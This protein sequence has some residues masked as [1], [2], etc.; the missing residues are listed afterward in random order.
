MSHQIP[1]QLKM[2]FG[3][4]GGSLIGSLVWP[5]VAA[6][7]F[8]ALDTTHRG[9]PF[10]LNDFSLLN[11][12]GFILGAGTGLAFT[13]ARGRFRQETGWLLSFALITLLFWRVQTAYN[14]WRIEGAR[15]ALVVYGIPM[16]W[17]CLLIVKSCK[18]QNTA[19]QK[20]KTPA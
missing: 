14:F 15:L 10:N 19:A 20:D 17:A 7:I 9:F 1:E 12:I 6:F 8:E 13:M 16:L 18:M 2:G 4:C 3:I 11:E 5:R